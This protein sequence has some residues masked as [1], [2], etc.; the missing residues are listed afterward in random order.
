MNKRI[1]FCITLLSCILLAGTSPA[2]TDFLVKATDGTVVVG[3]SMEFALG[4][5]SNIV[6]YPR[7]TK[8]VSQ[9]PDNATGISWQPKYG[10]LG[11]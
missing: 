6:V 5:D 11:V 8:M 2:C 3:R 1:L 10:Y 4:I 9:G 7:V